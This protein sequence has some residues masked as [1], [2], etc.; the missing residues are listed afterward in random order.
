MGGIFT[1]SLDFEL[2][3]GV[4]D[5][6]DRQ[7]RKTCYANTLKAIP[8]M[9]DL[10]AQHEVHVTWATVGSLMAKDQREWEHLKPATEPAYAVEEYS[11]YKWVR[12]HG[13]DE[14]FH[15]AHFAPNEIATILKFP[16]QELGTHT[17][18]HH[19]CLEQT[20]TPEAFEADLQAAKKAALKFGCELKSL[21][22][23]RNQFN[24][25]YLKVCYENGIR[26]VR[27]N[28]S[29]WF[30]RPI[31]DK[32][33]NVTRKFYRT[34]DAY[35]P[36]AK[37]RTSY[38][39]KMIAHIPGEPLQLPAS[40]LLRPWKPGFSLLNKLALT[41]VAQELKAAAVHDECYHLW[42]HPENFGDHPQENLANLRILLQHYQEC[43]KSFNMESRNMGEYETYLEGEKNTK[44]KAVA[45]KR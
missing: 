9:L 40:R 7:S 11:P 43:K 29:S 2:H 24:P 20:T 19:Y 4:F 36:L 44:Q 14:Q 25:Y 15:W 10:F 37:K 23:P 27:S 6:K 38:P 45:A 30:W 8:Q 13:L 17:F 16:G 21:V 42:W 1:I 12:Q 39:L 28:P 34:G 31:T 3:W 18:G 41:R 22:F 33:A 32:G 26:V 5:K 35:L